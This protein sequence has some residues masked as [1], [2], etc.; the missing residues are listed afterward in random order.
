MPDAGPAIRW[1]TRVLKDKRTLALARTFGPTLV[2]K[3]CEK[4]RSHTNHDEYQDAHGNKYHF[5]GTCD[6]H[7]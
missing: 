3:V 7:N 1:V 2:K 5:C 4:C 6:T